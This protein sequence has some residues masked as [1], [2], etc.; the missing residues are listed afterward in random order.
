VTP[1]PW[2]ASGGVKIKRA[3]EHIDN[4]YSEI[5]AAF[6][7][8]EYGIVT[9]DEPKT[10]STIWRARI[11]SE[12]DPRWGAIAGDAAHNL[13]SSLDILWR[14]VWPATVRDENRK[15][16]FPILSRKKFESRFG[17]EIEATKQPVVALLKEIKPY[18]GGNELLWM[19]S[20]IDNADKHR[21]LIPSFVCAGPTVIVLGDTMPPI[22]SKDHII[23][24]FF[25]AIPVHDGTVVF[26][27][28]AELRIMNVK[29]QPTLTVAFGEVEVVKG[30]PMLDTLVQMVGVVE[31][32][33][34]MLIRAGLLA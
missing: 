22:I 1:V 34:E 12:P 20:E 21:L 25:P 9:E 30:K 11:K 31:G 18:E 13:R 33:A 19:L 8:G 6:Q 4:L 27:A 5:N 10:G 3:K 23:P 17:G 7:R 14:Q 16:G 15:D 28:P 32:V 29:P 26:I 2:A 24:R